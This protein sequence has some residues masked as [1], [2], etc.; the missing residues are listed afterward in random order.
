MKELLREST[1]ELIQLWT[2]TQDLKLSEWKSTSDLV[3]KALSDAGLKPK[4]PAGLE[5]NQSKAEVAT[6]FFE[7]AYG[8]TAV[9]D[10]PHE[11]LRFGRETIHKELE[12][13]LALLKHLRGQIGSMDDWKDKATADQRQ[14]VRQA[15]EHM[16]REMAHYDRIANDSERGFFATAGIGCGF[17]VIAM[18][19]HVVLTVIGSSGFLQGP[20]L[21]GVLVLA[22]LPMAIGMVMQLAK[23][24]Q[25]AA[26]ESQLNAV[27]REARKQYQ[28]ACDH[29]ERQA[30]EH[31]KKLVGEIQTTEQ[32]HQKLIDAYRLLGNEPPESLRSTSEET[33]QAA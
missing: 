15:E 29:A 4:F 9:V 7:A 26:V 30:K 21:Y 17:G 23:G 12:K 2:R 24:A 1:A 19:A 22:L 33:K 11:M 16:R 32:K 20:V 27:V 28:A 31:Q 3:K 25:R 8:A 18:I 6:G 14:V 13:S 10:K 5:C